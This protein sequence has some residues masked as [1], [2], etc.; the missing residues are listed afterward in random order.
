MT[1]GDRFYFLT[2][3]DEYHCFLEKILLHY[4]KLS[5]KYAFRS[6]SMQQLAAISN[7]KK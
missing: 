4:Q 1:T 2:S 5:G 6:V 7:N 3:Q